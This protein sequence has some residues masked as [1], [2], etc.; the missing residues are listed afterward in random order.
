MDAVKELFVID[1]V[2]TKDNPRTVNTKSDSFKELLQ[3]IKST[4]VKVPVH[5]RPHPSQPGKY[6]LR[7]GERR[8]RAA[9]EA[10]LETIPA[11]IHEGM[12]DQDAFELTFI[13]N[14]AREDLSVLEEGRAVAI[15]MDKH[16]G[17]TAAVSA[18]LG[19]S[20][21]WVRLRQNLNK[22]LSKKWIKEIGKGE[23]SK[24][25]H[26]SIGHFA[27]V[28]RLSKADQNEI[29]SQLS[30]YRADHCTINELQ[31]DLDEYTRKLKSAK[32][33]LA[34]ADLYSKAGACLQCSKRSSCEPQLWEMDEV[35][36]TDI[37]DRCLD[38]KCWQAK[39]DAWLK[40]VVSKEKSPDVIYLCTGTC[41]SVDAREAADLLHVTVQPE[42][43]FKTGKQSDSKTVLA[44]Y[45]TGKKIGKLV[46]V[47]PISSGSTSAAVKGA[48]AVKTM[49][50]KRDELKRKRWF[51]VT[52]QVRVSLK[53]SG[54]DVIVHKDKLH[55]IVC[56]IRY[57]GT[58]SRWHDTPLNNAAALME[59]TGGA[60]AGCIIEALWEMVKIQITQHLHWKGPITQVS[61]SHIVRIKAAM[62]LF[63][64]CFNDL[65][66]QAQ[67]DYPTPK[68]WEQKADE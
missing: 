8:H 19:R 58:C 49:E 31:T 50:Q 60:D 57:M 10:G 7:A 18:K 37:H 66:K 47:Q 20:L 62:E 4:G 48:S 13:E 65:W 14:F 27:L 15:L 5:V 21:Q 40:D 33:D 54:S 30:V 35:G 55:A 34:D 6:D 22:N 68:S 39:K 67:A 3:S 38:V 36:N 2:P 41:L 52:E 46:W 9:T 44:L 12:S 16:K 25:R 28:A 43:R 61:D 32:W 23:Y 26:W 42:S 29:L 56:L 17:D 53:G 45:V 59:K 51:S 1:I 63:G 64:F 11:I 24:V